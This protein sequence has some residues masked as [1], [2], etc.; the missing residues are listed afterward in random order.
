MSLRRMLPFLLLLLAAGALYAAESDSSDEPRVYVGVL[1]RN[2]T[3]LGE[4]TGDIYLTDG[5]QVLFVP[6]VG[7]GWGIGGVIGV[8]SG[9]FGF[10]V[11]YSWSPHE[12]MWGGTDTFESRFQAYG[13]DIRWYPL[14]LGIFE[15]FALGGCS[16]YDL[17]VLDGATDLAVF[18][19]ETF[20][21]LGL[22]LGGGLRI[23][24]GKRLSLVV[25]SVYHWARFNTVDDFYGTNVTITDGLDAS[26]FDFGA[27]VMVY[28]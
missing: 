27:L 1:G 21:G 22:D 24:I 26:G 25:Q 13:L 23:G 2:V 3:V 6:E 11:F 15:P 20:Y 8:R 14:H 17:K 4:F 9:S 16:F 19:D 5:F 10:E 18:R 7:S 28:F 12:G